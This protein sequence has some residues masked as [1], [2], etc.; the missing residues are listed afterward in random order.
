MTHL[1]AAVAHL[2]PA[3]LMHPGA[4][5]TALGYVIGLLALTADDPADAIR[6]AMYAA[7]DVV[8]PAEAQSSH[9]LLESSTVVPMAAW[10]P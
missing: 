9:W 4:A 10:R 8:R 3:A 7:V 2:L 6:T 5:P 1:E